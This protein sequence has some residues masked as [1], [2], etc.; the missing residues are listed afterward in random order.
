MGRKTRQSSTVA[1]R[2]TMIHVFGAGPN[3]AMLEFSIKP[4]QGQPVTFSAY[5]NTPPKVFFAMA[6]VLATAF[7]LVRAVQVIADQNDPSVAKGVTMP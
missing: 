7:S 6:S 3:S 2:V 1:G 5:K 4:R